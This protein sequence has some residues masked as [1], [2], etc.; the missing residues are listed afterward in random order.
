MLERPLNSTSSL[1]DSRRIKLPLLLES[2]CQSFEINSDKYSD[3]EIPTSCQTEVIYKEAWCGMLCDIYLPYSV[4]TE[5]FRTC[6]DRPSGS[7]CSL[8]NRCRFSFSGLKRP[9]HGVVYSHSSSSECCSKIRNVL[10]LALWDFIT[11]SRVN[12]SY[13]FILIINPRSVMV[14]ENPAAGLSAMK[15]LNFIQER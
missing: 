9:G 8:Y 7:P 10:L 11:C 15:L 6:P 4:P 2:N 14:L 13:T 12:V 1:E 5:I 3:W